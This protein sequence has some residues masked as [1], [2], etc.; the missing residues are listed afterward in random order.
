[1]GAVARAWATD[2]LGDVAG[3]VVWDL[4][5]GVGDTAV[6]LAERGADVVSVDAD[7]RAV[8]WARAR[9]APRPVRFIAGRAEQVVD[10]LPEPHAVVL[11]P[12]RGGLDW[13]VT[14]RLT[15]APPARVAYVSC[16]PATLARDLSR[17]AV[18]YRLTALRAFDLFPQTAHVETVAVLEA[19]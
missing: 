4:Y 13:D 14:L 7:E 6:R 10:R 12:P 9:P 15:S 5:G 17:L 1:M 19:A 16:D 3:R 8:A 18:T 11:N 2:A